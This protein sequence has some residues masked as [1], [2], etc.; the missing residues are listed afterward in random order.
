[1]VAEGSA[2]VALRMAEALEDRTRYATPVTRI[3]I[4][5][6]GCAVETATGERFQCDAVVSAVPVGPLRR[7]AIEGVSRERL[8]S[9]D[10][11]RHALAAK[12]CFSYPDSFWEQQGLNGSAFMETTMIGGT[13][14]Q[15]EGIISTLIPPER[16]AALTHHLAADRGGAN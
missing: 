9:L 3:D 5:T 16:L 2:T 15:R 10:L 11:Q 4:A 6:N 12:V 14:P 1:M 8:A 13:W 7:I